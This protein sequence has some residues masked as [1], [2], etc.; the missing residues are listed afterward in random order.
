MAGYYA[1]LC[2]ILMAVIIVHDSKRML[3]DPIPAPGPAAGGTA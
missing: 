1:W 3:F 2:L